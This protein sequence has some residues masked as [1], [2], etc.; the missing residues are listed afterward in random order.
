[1]EEEQ[2]L[3]FGPALRKTITE[4]G[5]ESRDGCGAEPSEQTTKVS[6][7]PVYSNTEESI[8]ILGDS[9]DSDLDSTS[10]HTIDD[11]PLGST[12]ENPQII[13]LSIHMQEFHDDPSESLVAC[14]TVASP[15]SDEWS[16]HR[17]SP[18]EGRVTHARHAAREP[19]NSS[20][21]LHSSLQRYVE[22]ADN[23]KLKH[24][25]G[26]VPATI[27]QE[28]VPDFLKLDHEGEIA[29]DSKGIPAQLRGGTLTDLIEQLTRHDR[30]D[31]PFNNTFL[32]TYGSFTSASDLFE[33]LVKRWNVQPPYGLNPFGLETWVNKKQKPI[34]FRVVN[35]LKIWFDSYWVEEN[36]DANQQLMRRVYS[37]AKETVASGRTFGVGPLMTAIKHRVGTGWTRPVPT[38]KLVEL[39]E[40]VTSIG[41][42]VG[43]KYVTFLVFSLH[44]NRVHGCVLIGPF[45]ADYNIS[46][47]TTFDTFSV[48]LIARADSRPR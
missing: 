43:R 16:D 36:S 28:D 34:R 25:F 18:S 38:L 24:F 10:R 26:E 6:L 23:S 31:S 15:L 8:N 30:L 5:V 29:Y 9:L 27:Q 19:E 4:E 14:Q 44:I 41:F 2:D 22:F 20:S 42:T 40:L 33:L 13:G 21:Q 3:A 11:S 37:F 17:S 48:S 1:M 39:V 47:E 46:L 32:L 12:L 7:R 35:I 45:E